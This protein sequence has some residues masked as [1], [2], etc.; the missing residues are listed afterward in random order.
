[1]QDKKKRGFNWGSVVG[2]LIFI[3]IFAGAPLLRL[4]RQMVG[5]S[6]TLPANLTNLI[7]LA[8]AA[9][10]VLSIVASAV[11]A[12]GN[13]SRGGADTRLPTGTPAPPSRGPSAPLPPF[14]GPSAPGMPPIQSLPQQQSPR[15]FTMPASSSQPKMPPPPRFEPVISPRILV[16]GI[17]GLIVLGLLGML[18]LGQNLP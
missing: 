14:G 2:W 8:F 5:G 13:A 18:V 6:V 17:L 11:R 4:L 10:V 1:M 12:L 15:A 7:P 16:I 9:L 3:L